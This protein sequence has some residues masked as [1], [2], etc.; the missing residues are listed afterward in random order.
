[1]R[2]SSFAESAHPFVKWAGG[3]GQL[4]RNLEVSIPKSFR[5]YYEPFL[6]GGAFFFHLVKTRP[7]FRAVLSDKN[8][9]LIIAYQTVRN[10]VEDLI[11]QLREHKKRYRLSPKK[12]YYEVRDCQP[13]G[14]IEK[15]A[16][17]IFLNKTC[18]NGLYRVNQ[19]GCFNVPHGQHR[20]PNICDGKNLRAVSNVLKLTEASLSV[21]DYECATRNAAANDL[22]YFDPP[23]QPVSS[24]S[25]FTSYT[26]CGFTFEDQ[27][28]L[29]SVFEKLDSRKCKILL[30]NSDVPE[31]KRMYSKFL[32]RR[33][34]ALRA[35]NCTGER[36]TGHTELIITNYGVPRRQ[37]KR[38]TFI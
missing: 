17:L 37:S 18:Y 30:S 5:T 22:V 29:F 13:R 36:R 15:A 32:V 33:V 2:G 14:D 27:C 4:L 7:P 31:I 34:K 25:N 24:T 10:N 3:K 26:N 35:I 16:R 12:Y 11:L 1:M 38:S 8:A 19:K 21:A 28:C 9:E 6:G 20:N 23:Y